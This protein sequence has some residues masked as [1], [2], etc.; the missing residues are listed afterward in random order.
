[1]C[2]LNPILYTCDFFGIQQAHV[3]LVLFLI[4]A[5]SEEDVLA[6]V[7]DIGGHS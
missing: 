7:N 1:M 4:T 3:D 6:E 5:G 2:L